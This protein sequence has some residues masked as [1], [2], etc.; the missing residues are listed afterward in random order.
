MVDGAVEAEPK[1]LLYG[2]VGAVGG[3]VKSLLY[4]VF[5]AVEGEAKSLR[6]GVDGAVEGERTLSFPYEQ[7]DGTEF[8][9]HRWSR[10]GS[11]IISWTVLS[12]T[13]AAFDFA[14]AS[15]VGAARA[16]VVM[17]RGGRMPLVATAPSHLAARV[18]VDAATPL[19]MV[20][21]SPSLVILVLSASERGRAVTAAAGRL[22]GKLS[23]CSPL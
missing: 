17:R 1:L 9:R 6:Y 2:V 16:L 19:T 8:T 23:S 18:F 11:S 20:A 15:V 5:G 22:G 7:E 13:T 21:A 12:L 10:G 3:E 4:G 14:A